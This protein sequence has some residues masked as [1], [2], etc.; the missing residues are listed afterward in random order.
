MLERPGE[1]FEEGVQLTVVGGRLRP[2]DPAPPFAL[3]AL[4]EGT[5][6]AA[7]RSAAGAAR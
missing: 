3:D 6:V 7:A 1:A 5:A 4:P 2:G